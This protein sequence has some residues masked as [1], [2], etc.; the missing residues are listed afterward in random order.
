MRFANPIILHWLWLLPALWL[1]LYWFLRRRYQKMTRFAFKGL[2]D[3]LTPASSFRALKR[4]YYVLLGAVAFLVFALARPQWGYVVEKVKQQG[5]DIILAVDV[6]KSML[7]SDVKPN[8]L[9]RSKLA[10]KDL[11]KK[12]NGDRLGL[13]PFA[14]EAFMMCPLTFDYGGFASSLESLSVESIP[15]GGTNIAST[16]KGA[17]KAFG[18]EELK[19]KALVILT[20]GEEEQGDALAA[21][22]EA[23]KKGIRIFTIG[24][25]TQEGDLIQVVNSE[26]ALGFLK[27][28][29]GNYIKSHLNEGLLQRIA[30]ETGGAYV[31]SSGAEFGLDY[32][33]TH[34]LSKWAKRN[35]QEREQR[36]Y[37]E[38]FQWPLAVGIILLGLSL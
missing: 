12:V 31:R 22:L 4:K 20:D 11:L 27:D 35:L 37:Y 29:Q 9:E 17:L 30:F 25:G 26:G 34:E 32:L 2:L 24:I 14:G 3:E 8:R 15:L 13:M 23:K 10:I 18:T 33:Y 36:R 28:E 1:M 6:S 16:I 38:Q 19:Y 7:T 5:L 21:A